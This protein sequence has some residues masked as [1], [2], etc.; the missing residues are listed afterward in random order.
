MGKNIEVPK[1]MQAR[2]TYGGYIVPYFVAWYLDNKPCHEKMP[3]AIPSFV[4]IDVIRATH[5]RTQGLCWCCGKMLGAHKWFV[6]GPASAV[7]QQ[8]VEPPSHMDCAQYAVQVCPF[9]LN[10]DRQMRAPKLPLKERQEV[11][12]G[13]ATY[14]PGIS[15]LWATKSYHVVAV[16]KNKGIYWFEPGEPEVIEFWREGRKATRPEIDAAF[17]L[18]LKANS[19]DPHDREVAWRIEKVMR[20]APEEG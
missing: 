2:P 8:S 1:T 4:T 19:I 10:P 6:F 7:A 20:F 11:N 16:S 9:I 17:D 12:P 13:V 5:C 18:S 15:V 3:G 14:N